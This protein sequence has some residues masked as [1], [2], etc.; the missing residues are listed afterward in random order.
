MS[1]MGVSEIYLLTKNIKDYKNANTMGSFSKSKFLEAL[2]E[3]ES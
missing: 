1:K 3:I 2:N